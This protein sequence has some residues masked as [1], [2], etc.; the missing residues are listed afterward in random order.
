MLKI[1]KNHDV[2]TLPS[3]FDGWGAVVNEAASQGCALMLSD[4]VGAGS[5]FLKD[6]VNG[7]M[8]GIDSTSII[9]K[10]KWFIDNQ[11]KLKEYKTNSLR[12]YKNYQ[13]HEYHFQKVFEECLP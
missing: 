8:V 4:R 9:N 1:Y 6:S 13:K 12:M 5:F 3:V 10:L 2:L 11:D 7:C